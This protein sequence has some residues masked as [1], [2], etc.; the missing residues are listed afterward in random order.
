MKV[1]RS[2]TDRVESGTDE[3]I[4]RLGDDTKASGSCDAGKLNTLVDWSI[5]AHSA[6]VTPGKH[7]PT[8]LIP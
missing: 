2:S 6:I 1:D 8:V 3:L 4:E 7:I 5:R